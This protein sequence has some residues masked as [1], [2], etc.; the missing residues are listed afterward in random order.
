MKSSGNDSYIRDYVEDIKIGD[1]CDQGHQMR[2]NI[3]WFGENLNF[4]NTHLAQIAAEECEI[5]IIVGTSMQVSPAKDIPW[6]TPELTLIYYVD[7][8]EADFYVPKFRMK[9]NLFEHIKQPGTTGIPQ[10]VSAIRKI[11]GV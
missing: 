4:M 11:Y 2:P 7:P 3:V 6:L 9:A 5:C 10:V 1:V 8:G